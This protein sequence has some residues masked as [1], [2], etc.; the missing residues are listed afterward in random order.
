MLETY[1]ERV[2]LLKMGSD[3]KTIE[4]LYIKNNG[5]NIIIQRIF[6][7]IFGDNTAYDGVNY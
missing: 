2:E 1:K 7:G 5:F 4:R 3:S 6:H